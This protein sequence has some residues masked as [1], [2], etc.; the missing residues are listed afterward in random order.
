MFCRTKYCFPLLEAGLVSRFVAIMARR[1]K[2]LTCLD[3]ATT[4]EV[5]FYSFFC[6]VSGEY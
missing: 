1:F 3:S 6:V 2:L 5:I 4:E